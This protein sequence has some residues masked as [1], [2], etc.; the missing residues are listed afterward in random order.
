MIIIDDPEITNQLTRQLKRFD[1]INIVG[2]YK[3]PSKA[4]QKMKEIKVDAVFLKIE[5]SRLNGLVLAK[6]V[7]KLTHCPHVVFVSHNPKYAVQAYELNALDYLLYPVTYNRLNI[8]ISRLFQRM[9]RPTHRKEQFYINCFGDLA[10]FQEE[11]YQP[12]DIRWRTR[13]T[14]EVF[15]Y[16]LLH[17]GEKVRKDY[18]VDVIWPNIN[19][20]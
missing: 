16:L 18:L 8:T 4:L 7:S 1:S 19:R 3:H 17:N 5:M 15:S 14:E 20:E 13:K 11:Q 6:H 9:K 2:K 12:L 10:I